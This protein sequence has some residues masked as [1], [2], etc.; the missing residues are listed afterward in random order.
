[1]SD[2]ILKITPT[3]PAYIPDSSSENKCRLYLEEL[4]GADQIEL[5]ETNDVEFIDPGQ[6]LEHVY[7]NICNRELDLGYWSTIVDSASLNNFNDLTFLTPC[8]RNQASLNSLRYAMPAGFAKFSIQIMN[9][10][11]ELSDEDIQQLQTILD[12]PL[13]TIWAHY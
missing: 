12:T 1:M 3:E 10:N 4:F 9:L 8:C 5:L 7:C 11:F 13:R 2:I 6:N